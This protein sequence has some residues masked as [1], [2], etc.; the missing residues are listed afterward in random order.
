MF[1]VV[2]NEILL[3]LELAQVRECGNPIE[4]SV[5]TSLHLIL[6]VHSTFPSASLGFP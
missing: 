1:L 6:A 2:L 3:V 4:A 5:L